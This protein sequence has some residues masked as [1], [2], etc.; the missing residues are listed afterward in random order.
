MRI[1]A[2]MRANS[3]EIYSGYTMRCNGPWSQTF[4]TLRLAAFCITLWTTE[5]IKLHL[6]VKVKYILSSRQGPIQNTTHKL[7]SSQ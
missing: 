5:E 4:C 7:L 1:Q 6:N 3:R 2:E